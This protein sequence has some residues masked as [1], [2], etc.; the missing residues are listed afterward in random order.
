MKEHFNSGEKNGMW[1]GDEAGYEAIHSWVRKRKIKPLLC[2]RCNK[3]KSFDLA[4]ISGKYL[5]DIEDFEYLCRKCHMDSDGR[6]DKLRENGKS[7]KLSFKICPIC[8]VEFHRDTKKAIYC[9]ISCSRIGMWKKRKR[10]DKRICK[11]CKKVFIYKNKSSV[12]CSR[13]CGIKYSWI[14]RKLIK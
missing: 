4:N 12:T 11:I 7:R 10:K 1:K 5:R 9:S 8:K 2:E 13:S 14:K 3:R 6:N